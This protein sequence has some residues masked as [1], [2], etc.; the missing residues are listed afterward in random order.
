MF[1]SWEVIAKQDYASSYVMIAK[2]T[3]NDNIEN[4]EKS[5][6]INWRISFISKIPNRIDSYIKRHN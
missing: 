6:I 5:L 4:I 2:K 3:T 1:D